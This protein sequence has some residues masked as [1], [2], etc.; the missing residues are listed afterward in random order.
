MHSRVRQRTLYST[1]FP[2]LSL[3]PLIVIGTALAAGAGEARDEGPL[4]L[5]VEFNQLN[6]LDISKAYY[7][8]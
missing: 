7:E 5:L 2:E 6:F 3:T 4:L 1:V 8:S